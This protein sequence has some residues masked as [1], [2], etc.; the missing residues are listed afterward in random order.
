M[1]PSQPNQRE[2]ALWIANGWRTYHEAPAAYKELALHGL[3]SA[4]DIAVIKEIDQ[5]PHTQAIMSKFLE[6]E[7]HTQDLPHIG[8]P[9]GRELHYN[10]AAAFLE[11]N[12]I[13]EGSIGGAIAGEIASR[14]YPDDPAKRNEAAKLLGNPLDLLFN[15]A[16]AL[17]A[18]HQ[19]RGWHPGIHEKLHGGRGPDRPWLGREP[20]GLGPDPNT[21]LGMGRPAPDTPITDGNFRQEAMSV[22]PSAIDPSQHHGAGQFDPSAAMS[23]DPSAIDPSQHHGGGP[24][25]Q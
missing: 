1:T 8:I 20:A 14:A 24:T 2:Q 22:D 10:P 7:R 11:G 17:G 21:P 15:H 13:V 23:V 25:A 9:S 19:T 5:N 4:S 12:A 6:M 18:G 16:D 3:Y